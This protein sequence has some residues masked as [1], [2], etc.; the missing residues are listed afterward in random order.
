MEEVDS[1][2]HNDS[3]HNIRISNI[4]IEQKI[5]KLNRIERFRDD[6]HRL[7]RITKNEIDLMTQSYLDYFN[8]KDPKRGT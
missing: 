5:Q 7:I 6:Q 8:V 1:N 4:F 3:N 2:S